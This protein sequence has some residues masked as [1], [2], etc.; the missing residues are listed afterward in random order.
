MKI[1]VTGGCGFLGSHVCEAFRKKGFEVIAYDNMTK[2]EIDRAGF[3][4]DEVRG[5]NARVLRDMGVEIVVGDIRNRSQLLDYASGCCFIAHTAAQPAMTISWEDPDLDFTTNVVGTYNVLTVARKYKIPVASCSSVHVY[6]PWINDSLKEEDT[7][8][9]RDPESISED[10]KIMNGGRNGLISPL[11]ASKAS[12]E[13]YTKAFADMYDVKSAAFRYT[14]I[15]GPRQFGGEDHG[16]VANF[17]IR[18]IMNRTITIFGNGKQL[19]DILYASD[20]AAAFLAYQENPVPGIYNIGGG[21]KNMISLLECIR[22][23]D[24]LSGNK[25]DIKF[26]AARD[27]DLSYFVCNI[28]R[29]GTKLNWKPEILPED[30]VNRL[31]SW[32]KENQHLFRSK[33]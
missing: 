22:L 19:R 4:T 17:S 27:G 11:H 10:D 25:S 29:A 21:P 5:F 31:I 9:T 14:G 24:K 23:I 30:G 6:G 1:L 18:N 33:N 15:Y 7:R 2:H 12:A 32:I 28:Q 3:N 20:A 8:F 13:H 26:D 16:W